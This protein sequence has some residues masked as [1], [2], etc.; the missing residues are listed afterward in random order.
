MNFKESFPGITKTIFIPAALVLLI[1]ATI[2]IIATTQKQGTPGSNSIVSST[3]E[4]C[5][6]AVTVSSG[7]TCG[8]GVIYSI[9]D[10]EITIAT[11]SH[12]ISDEGDITVTFCD[13]KESPASLQRQDS[14]LDIAFL[15]VEKS[16]NKNS[17]N[18][19][20]A[21]A[22]SDASELPSYTNPGTPVYV[23][24]SI[25]G[26]TQS[27]S[28]ALLSVY[29]EDFGMDLMCCYL[30]ADPGMSGCGL[31]DA[32]A[33]FLGML[34]GGTDDGKSVYIPGSKIQECINQAI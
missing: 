10:N 27:G 3:D 12:V 11:A 17:D 25:T 5:Y 31:F 4:I 34:L 18:I 28:I 1:A 22:I 14:S 29:S 7:K 15:I 19:Y 6:S 13:K 20:K 2:F 32:D 21:V 9:D 23:F 8:N 24:N 30:D 16:D 33:H 26:K